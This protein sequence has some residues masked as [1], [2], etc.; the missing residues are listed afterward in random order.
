MCAL[1]AYSFLNIITNMKFTISVDTK[2]LEFHMY[3]AKQIIQLFGNL[4]AKAFQDDWNREFVKWGGID[5]IIQP[6][7]EPGDVV[8]PYFNIWNSIFSYD[9]NFLKIM[10]KLDEIQKTLASIPPNKSVRSQ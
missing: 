9:P 7:I 10:E 3:H 4:T 5:S 8:G 2:T 6:S 1:S